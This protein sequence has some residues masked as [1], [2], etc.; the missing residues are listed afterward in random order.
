[1]SRYLMYFILIACQT[2]SFGI[3]C[4]K[5]KKKFAKQNNFVIR[6]VTFRYLKKMTA[7]SSYMYSMS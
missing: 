7:N 4:Q 5:K 3:P 6:I 1:M 2:V